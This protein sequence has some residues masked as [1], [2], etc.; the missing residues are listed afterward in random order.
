ML[1][2]C[3]GTMARHAV[4]ALFALLVLPAAGCA[5]HDGYYAG[6]YDRN[7]YYGRVYDYYGPYGPRQSYYDAYPPGSYYY[8]RAYGPYDRPFTYPGFVYAP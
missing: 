7:G 8:G 6:Y 5:Y 1:R 2:K 4:A 3:V